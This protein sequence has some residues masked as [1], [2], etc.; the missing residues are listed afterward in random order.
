MLIAENSNGGVDIEEHGAMKI[1][2][3]V[4]LH[5]IAKGER[6]GVAVSHADEAMKSY[7]YSARFL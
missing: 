2:R 3:D 5:F 7:N 6:D 1:W 4:Y